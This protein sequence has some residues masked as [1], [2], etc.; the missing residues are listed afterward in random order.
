[1]GNDL[2]GLGWLGH[3]WGGSHVPS[4]MVTQISTG[5]AG[6]EQNIKREQGEEPFGWKKLKLA[7]GRQFVSKG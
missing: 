7:G 6:M 2:E 4:A 3:G 5:G 1:M